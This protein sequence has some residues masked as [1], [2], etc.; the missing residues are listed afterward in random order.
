VYV[1]K[2]LKTNDENPRAQEVH[3]QESMK[4][5]RWIWVPEVDGGKDL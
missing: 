2:H 3:E 1:V 5:V 4:V